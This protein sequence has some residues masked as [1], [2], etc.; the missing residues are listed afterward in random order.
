MDPPDIVLSESRMEQATELLRACSPRDNSDEKEPETRRPTFMRQ[1]SKEMQS[2][3]DMPRGGPSPVSFEKQRHLS[4]SGQPE[5]WQDDGDDNGTNY[6]EEDKAV[7]GWSAI[8]SKVSAPKKS[9]K[10]S[11]KSSKSKQSEVGADGAN[12]DEDSEK[13]G[14][15]T[16]QKTSFASLP[17]DSITDAWVN[18]ESGKKS[19]EDEEDEE[20]KNL[21]Q[22]QKPL[23]LPQ[24]SYARVASHEAINTLDDP[25]L[26]PASE[27]VALKP[28]S[29]LPMVI[30]VEET[31]ETAESFVDEEGFEQVASRKAKRER[32][33]SKRYSQ[34]SDD[35]ENEAADKET[36]QK[37]KEGE[38]N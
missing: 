34:V 19:S 20:L 23:A 22:V 27:V 37:G 24:P 16:V 15:P 29:T 18:D 17:T 8:T 31:E 7:S 6:S 30:N 25:P 33:I 11:R 12:E 28:A 5:P 4:V 35:M 10:R 1:N 36:T 14:N 21:T 26:P 13:K 32:K 3:V 9:G 38:K 2:A